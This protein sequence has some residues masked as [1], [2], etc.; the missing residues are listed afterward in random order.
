[1]SFKKIIQ[2]D[3]D[4]V[5]NEYDGKY[6]KDYIHPIKKGAY[7]F[8]EKLSYHYSLELFTVREIDLCKN[9][10][11]ENNIDKFFDNVTNTKN[12]FASIFI[13]DRAINFNGDYEKIFT[14]IMNFQPYWKK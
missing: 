4:G 6:I 5:L 7:E 9:W 13:D 1:M 14:E 3:L 10:L 8:L 12:S 2:I 11:V